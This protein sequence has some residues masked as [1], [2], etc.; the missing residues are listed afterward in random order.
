[1]G[2]GSLRDYSGVI[3]DSYADP[4]NRWLFNKD[5]A[6]LA[7]TRTAMTV[8]DTRESLLDVLNDLQQNSIDYYATLKSVYTQNRNELITDGQAAYEEF[9]D[10]D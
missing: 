7:Y 5:E 2:P 1:M 8:L 6:I 9:P 10:F 3:V 4:L